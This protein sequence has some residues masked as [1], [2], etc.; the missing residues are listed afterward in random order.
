M[1]WFRVV[2]WAMDVSGRREELVGLLRR[3]NNATADELARA[4]GVSVRTVFRDLDAMRTRGFALDGTLGRAGGVW[5][6]GYTDRQ[7]RR[8]RRRVEPHGLLVRAPLWYIIAWDSARDGP[9]SFRMDRIRAP[10]VDEATFVPRP[11][12][13]FG[14]VCFGAERLRR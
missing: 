11:L 5:R 8:T 14:D 2:L 10:R 13:A 6:F 1:S 4:L 3:R 9:R 7:G 12:R